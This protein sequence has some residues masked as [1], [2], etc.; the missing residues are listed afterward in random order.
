[1]A[2]HYK[3]LTLK[4][5][6]KFKF[7][8]PHITMNSVLDYLEDNHMLTV[9][10]KDDKGDAIEI[11]TGMWSVY[12]DGGIRINRRGRLW[13]SYHQDT[14]EDI[15]AN[16]NGSMVVIPYGDFRKHDDHLFDDH[17]LTIPRKDMEKVIEYRNK[18]EAAG[19]FKAN[20][21]SMDALA[22]DV[23]FQF[24]L[25]N[26]LGIEKHFF[27]RLHGKRNNEGFTNKK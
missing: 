1:M 27:D 8:A 5:K 13:G 3:D 6:L 15:L 11:D 20:G 25:I 17:T 21:M 4:D 10:T 14:M 2:I 19:G 12:G 7:W 22:K 18:F 23:D 9:Q 26:K 24:N 16:Q